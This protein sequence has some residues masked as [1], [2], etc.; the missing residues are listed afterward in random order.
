MSDLGGE[1]WPSF[2]C[3]EAGQCVQPIHVQA[4]QNWSAVHTMQ[5]SQN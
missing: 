1:V 3:V 5:Y 2:L 4:G